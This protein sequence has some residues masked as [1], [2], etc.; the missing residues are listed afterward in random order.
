M[1]VSKGMSWTLTLTLVLCGFL[2]HAS[3][4]TPFGAIKPVV[5]APHV[6][7]APLGMDDALWNEVPSVEVA[8][9]G[10]EELTGKKLVVTTKA[11]YTDDSIYMLFRWPDATHSVI[12]GAWK[13]DGKKWTRLKGDE[14]RIAVVWEITRIDGFASKGCTATC[15]VPEGQ[16]AKYGKFATKSE[17]EKGD[18]WHWKAARSA[19]YGHADEQ[20]VTVAADK[21]GRRNDAG[22]G[23]DLTNETQDKSKPRYMQDPAK[24]A[25]AP[26]F[27]LKEEAVEIK[28]YSGFKAGDV[29]P[30]RLL[31]RPEGSRFDV[32]AA[33]RYANGAWTVM[34]YRKLDTGNSDDVAFDPRREYSFAI[35]VFDDAS[36]EHSSDSEGLTLRFRR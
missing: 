34:L 5:T 24:P 8:T 32:K 17:A 33:S 11:V 2:I 14:D 28:D 36:D 16:A 21:T 3:H 30:H 31:V 12:K 15:H 10:K 26:G 6:K 27:L 29:V 9:E 19:P 23:G 1:T 22:A 20:W 7:R 4:Q 25:S 18:L 35:G 13:F